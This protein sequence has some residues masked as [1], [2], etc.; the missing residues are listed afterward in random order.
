M[1]TSNRPPMSNLNFTLNGRQCQL[2]VDASETLL[3]ALR[4]RT[5]T[6]SVKDGCSP[7]GQ[8]GCCLA[9]VDGRAIT[10]CSLPAAK[11]EGKSVVTLEGIDAD[12]RQTYSACFAE[13][14]GLQCGFCIPGIVMRAHHLL[15]KNPDPQ[16]EEIVKALDG[17]LCRC[18]GYKKI[19]DAVALMARARRGEWK[20]GG[21]PL[22]GKVGESLKRYQAEE[23][24]IG[25]R[26]YVDDVQLDGMLYGAMVLSPHPRARVL[27]IDSS[28]A[29]ALPGV[30]RVATAQDVPGDRYYG[31][32]FADWPGLVA[33]GEEVRYVGDVV[34]VVAA[35]SRFQAREAAK[36]V[37]E[38]YEV[39]PAVLDPEYGLLPE[40]PVVN[41]RNPKG[42][43]LLSRSHIARGNV[44]EAFARS[45]HI[46]EGKWQ[47]QRIEHLFLE[48]ESCVA[49]PLEGGRMKL[50]T[51]GQGIFD[52]R[53]QVASFLG[54]SEDDV[55]VE[56]M[57]NGGAFGG[58]EDMSVQ[59]QT[60]L[61]AYLTGRPVKL[62][63][64]RDESV[65]I[66]PKRHPLWMTYKVGCDAEGRLTAVQAYMIGDS[67]AY[68]SVGG[69]V[70]ERAAGHSCGPYVVPNV[71]VEAVAVYTNN[72]PCGAMRGFGVNQSAFAIEG[73]LDQLATKA[74]LDGWTIRR[75][76][77]LE[78]GQMVTTGQVVKEGVGL[79]ETLEA[80]KGRYYEALQA[81]KK[82][83][84]ACGLKNT[85]IGNGVAEWG[86]SRLVVEDDLSVSVHI[87][88]TEMGQG[89]LTV[90]IQFAVEMTGLPAEV[91]HPKVDT[92]FQLGSGQTTG[93]RATFFVG[94]AV[95]SAAGKLGE[96]L[97]SGKTLEDL[98]GQIFA[99]DIKV[100]DTTALGDKSRPPK[101]HSAYSFATQLCI[102]DEKGRVAKMIAAHDV[103]KVVNPSLCEGQLEGSLHMGLGYALSEELPCV[104]GMPV[105]TRLRDIGVLRAQD[106]PEMEILLLEV[107][108]AE[109]PMGVKG[110]GEIGLV[111]TAAAVASALYAYD[112]QTRYRLPMKES[113]AGM[114]MSVGR[115]RGDRATWR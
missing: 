98:K 61:L 31:L 4:D 71:D 33:E 94:K 43:N 9:L 22:T 17:H 114:A 99:A 11:A 5:G 76:N 95:M 85:G 90:A 53:R 21:A 41:S 97:R 29:E 16:P 112:G 26:P 64:S 100:D 84:I 89:L 18:T 109:G 63:L 35:E 54:K 86:K 39:L 15:E 45:A 24:A 34:A 102:L 47:T 87:G 12:L 37:Q 81:G 69:K 55:D 2:E 78:N 75:R 38:Q 104:A 52:D 51:Q 3:H 93:S 105:T 113:P 65:R 42:H 77:A 57:P 28:A 67:G 27:S 106:M 108:S 19:Q 74:G 79:I 36:A 6:C 1:L 46:V 44:E 60:A 111:P 88:Y 48:P 62:T 70:L 20:P 66:H 49:V 68:A 40:A 92:K 80:V 10:I 8:C 56:L 115:I 58:K 30:I 82:I 25:L 13:A 73:C 7:Q 101:T 59:A 96:A 50:Y 110:V 32:L 83:G 91:F 103:G 23:T 14:A 72:P 107:P